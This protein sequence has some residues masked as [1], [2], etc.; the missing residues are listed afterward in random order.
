MVIK[1][2]RPNPKASD[3][4]RNLTPASTPMLLSASEHK[5]GGT[6]SS[7]VEWRNR[8]LRSENIT[9]SLVWTAQCAGE[10][11]IICI[12]MK[13]LSQGGHG[14]RHLQEGKKQPI[15][16]LCPARL[17][18]HNICN[19]HNDLTQKGHLTLK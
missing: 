13:L 1:N 6:Q 3:V 11:Y 5:A 7:G 15:N 9:G 19:P 4:F 14:I 8:D 16:V 2:T 10:R 18:L 17:Q 12:H